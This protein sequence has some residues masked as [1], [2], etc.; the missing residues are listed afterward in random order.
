MAVKIKKPGVKRHTQVV[1][2][3]HKPQLPLGEIQDDSERKRMED[4][5]RE[6]KLTEEERLAIIEKYGPPKMPLG[7]YSN[8]TMHKRMKGG[9][10]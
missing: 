2:P 1:I 4:S 10:A 9:A 3:E 8:I 7:S 5:Y 6:Y